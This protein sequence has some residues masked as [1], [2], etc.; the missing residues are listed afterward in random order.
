MPLTASNAHPVA[1][2]AF[3]TTTAEIFSLKPQHNVAVIFN[4]S[5]SLDNHGLSYIY[6]IIVD[7]LSL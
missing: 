3:R 2:P 4:S 5:G 7:M 6:L 1:K